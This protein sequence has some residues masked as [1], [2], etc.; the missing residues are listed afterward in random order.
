MHR[1]EKLVQHEE[2]SFLDW[3]DGKLRPLIV[4]ATD[5]LIKEPNDTTWTRTFI[6]N[7]SPLIVRVANWTIDLLNERTDWTFLDWAALVGKWIVSCIA[8]L[9]LVIY[10]GRCL[11]SDA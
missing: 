1:R 11:T 8:L 10:P 7:V 3:E 5:L 4:Q 6:Q 2:N 9:F